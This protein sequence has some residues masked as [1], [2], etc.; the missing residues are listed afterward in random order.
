MPDNNLVFRLAT[1]DD[2]E[3]VYKLYCDVCGWLHN[4]RGITDQWEGEPT[5]DEIQE[6]VAS[7]QLHLAV[8]QDE[9]AGAFVSF[10]PHRGRGCN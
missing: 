6:M 8:L 4:V 1:P 10:N 3:P 5:K 2:V 9:V 7:G